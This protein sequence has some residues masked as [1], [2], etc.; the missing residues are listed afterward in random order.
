VV[1]VLETA[2]CLGVCRDRQQMRDGQLSGVSHRQMPT[3]RR[4]GLIADGRAS[5]IRQV[6]LNTLSLVSFT[7]KANVMLNDVQQNIPCVM[8]PNFL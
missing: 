5:R 8:T 1:P 4:R 3:T 6:E 7:I 2:G